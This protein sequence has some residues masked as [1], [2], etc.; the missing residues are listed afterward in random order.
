M[1]ERIT[2]MDINTF[3]RDMIMA[4]NKNA[5]EARARAMFEERVE[6]WKN[7]RKAQKVRATIEMALWLVL[8]IVFC[9]AS[10]RHGWH[11]VVPAVIGMF[12]GFCVSGVILSN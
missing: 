9:V 2:T 10:Y 8:V 5:E 6:K 11:D 3:E 1:K 4:V 12:V 7:R